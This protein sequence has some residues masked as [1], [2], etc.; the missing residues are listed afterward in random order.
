[1]HQRIYACKNVILTVRTRGHLRAAKKEDEPLL[2]RWAG[3][4]CRD[5]GIPDEATA[6]I[7][8]VTGLTAKGLVYVWEDGEITSM[9]GLTR[10]MRRGFSVSL[11]DTPPQFR[12][13]GYATTCVAE[14]TKLMLAAG[15]TFCCLYTDLANSTSNR[16]YQKIGYQ[17][18]CDVQDW[19]FK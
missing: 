19:I 13:K 8:R 12:N 18:V 6:T 16:I 9:A 15:K 4:F 7:A 17:P 2:M 3:E 5:A 1:M 10:E 14:L 11:V